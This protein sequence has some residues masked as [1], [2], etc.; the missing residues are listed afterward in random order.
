MDP[1]NPNRPLS[2]QSGPPTDRKAPLRQEHLVLPGVLS[3]QQKE[4]IFNLI[5][6]LM[7]DT[8]VERRLTTAAAANVSEFRAN[9]GA[10]FE[11]VRADFQPLLLD[12]ANAL[13]LKTEENITAFLTE[14]SAL[15]EK[16]Q[17]AEAKLKALAAND[18]V[19]QE[20]VLRV[21]EESLRAFSDLFNIKIKETRQRAKDASGS[22]GDSATSEDLRRVLAQVK[23]LAKGI[24]GFGL[25]KNKSIRDEILK[26]LSGYVED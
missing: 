11:R 6:V 1:I 14:F 3:D 7:V 4:E 20:A 15:V 19:V 17:E 18:A 24:S 2:R 8:G 21:Q 13:A 26:L 23:G 22:R 10:M 25:L 16:K 5:N 9:V 12:A